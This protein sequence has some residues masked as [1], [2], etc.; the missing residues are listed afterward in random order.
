MRSSRASSP[1]RTVSIV[2][3]V[4]LCASVSVRKPLRTYNF[5]ARCHGLFQS[6][7]AKQKLQLRRFD[8]CI[9]KS[10]F[11][12]PYGLTV[13]VPEEIGRLRP[14]RSEQQLQTG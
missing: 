1:C 8:V 4:A 9:G 13:A 11:S 5:K 3:T 12:T 6:V 7:G 2:T 10:V 14:R